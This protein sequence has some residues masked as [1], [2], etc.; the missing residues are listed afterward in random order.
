MFLKFKLE[1]SDSS[2]KIKYNGESLQGIKSIIGKKLDLQEELDLYYYDEDKDKVTLTDEESWQICLECA[3]EALDP[4]H[5]GSQNIQ[6]IVKPLPGTFV[7]HVT[8]TMTGVEKP[9]GVTVQSTPPIQNSMFL[10]NTVPQVVGNYTSSLFGG[11]TPTTAGGNN[12]VHTNIV[13]DECKMHPLTGHRF[14]SL[15]TEDFDLCQTCV[16]NP[17]YATQT[18]IRIPYYSQKENETIYSVKEFANVIKTFSKSLKEP[19]S[20]EMKSIVK[21]LKEAF[22]SAD[23]SSLTNFV[24]K[25]PG[26]SYNQLY[27]LYVKSNHA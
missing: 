4:S 12:T 25:N 14:K 8:H 24:K 13:C 7:S 22:V 1:G 9:K 23:E 16:N 21:A 2:S 18:F 26:Q 19:M 15:T 6:L 3:G 10:S 20:P 27:A 17:K 5:G 11:L